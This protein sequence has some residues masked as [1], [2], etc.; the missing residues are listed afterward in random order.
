M[1]TKHLTRIDMNPRTVEQAENIYDSGMTF[2]RQHI[3]LTRI[4]AR[5]WELIMSS[6]CVYIYT[7]MCSMNF[8]QANV[9]MAYALAQEECPAMAGQ[10]KNTCGVPKESN[11]ST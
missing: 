11:R 2:L 5:S 4:S 7:C 8:K 9:W 1:L 10:A 6:A 3:V